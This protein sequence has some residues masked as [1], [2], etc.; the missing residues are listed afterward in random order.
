MTFLLDKLNST[1]HRPR[2][3]LRGIL[4]NDMAC[5]KRIANRV[6]SCPIL[7]LSGF[8]ALCDERFDLRGFLAVMPSGTAD[9][10]A[11]CSSRNAF[12]AFSKPRDN[13]SSNS[14]MSASLS[15]S[16]SLAF[17]TSY[18]AVS[19]KDV[20][21]SFSSAARNETRSGSMAASSCSPSFFS[22]QCGKRAFCTP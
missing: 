4:H 19:A 11:F 15:T 10:C 7:C 6:G 17:S 21:R 12:A 18:S 22:A 16:E 20:L 8:R 14:L 1:L 13:T 9:F 2:D 3:T 5:G